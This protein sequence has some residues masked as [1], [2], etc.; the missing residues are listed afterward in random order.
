MDLNKKVYV[1]ESN[2]EDGGVLLHHGEVDLPGDEPLGKH[3]HSVD[4][5][6][7][8]TPELSLLKIYSNFLRRFI[9]DFFEDTLSFHHQKGI[10][11]HNIFLYFGHF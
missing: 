1:C 10:I 7:Q 5:R 3:L 11:F 4:T 6:Q 8:D 2:V 9:D